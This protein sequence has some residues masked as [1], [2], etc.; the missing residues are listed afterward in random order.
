[1]RCF[2][3]LPLLKEARSEITTQIADIRQRFPKLKWVSEDALHITVIFLGELKQREVTAC[4]EVMSGLASL[5][6]AFDAV[7]DRVGTFPPKGRPKVFT[8]HL[9]EKRGVAG[10]LDQACRSVYAY[11]S[12]K[13]PESLRTLSAAAQAPRKGGMFGERNAFVPHCTLARVREGE[14]YPDLSD[15][16]GLRVA[17]RLTRCVLYNSVLG[18]NGPTYIEL[19]D[20]KFSAE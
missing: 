17:A 11:L 16:A 8:A 3:A 2:F 7:F 19:A 15:F 13:L 9:S 1:M 6:P 14:G 12:E 5:I 18:P 4:I 10:N 20:V